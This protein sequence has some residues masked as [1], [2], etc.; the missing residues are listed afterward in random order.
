MCLPSFGSCISKR[1]VSASNVFRAAQHNLHPSPERRTCAPPGA[2]DLQALPLSTC[3]PLVRP[4]AC[5]NRL[6]TMNDGASEVMTPDDT[7][8]CD[9]RGDLCYG[10]WD[11]ERPS[12]CRLSQ[13]PSAIRKCSAPRFS[14]DARDCALHCCLGVSGVCFQRFRPRGLTDRHQARALRSNCI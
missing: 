3:Q 11:G 8:L 2:P 9:V 7:E 6:A 5:V 4:L 13:R 1:Q 10:W 12:L 14:E